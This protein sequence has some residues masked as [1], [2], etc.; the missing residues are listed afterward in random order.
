MANY[1]P[2][3]HIKAL[4]DQQLDWRNNTPFVKERRRGRSE[5][6]TR[7]GIEGKGKG[8]LIMGIKHDIQNHSQI[9]QAVNSMHLPPKVTSYSPNQVKATKQRQP[10]SD[11]KTSPTPSQASTNTVI[12]VRKTPHNILE[13]EA[14]L[15]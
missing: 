8:T 9:G 10:S 2:D 5:N 15:Y 4:Y 13:Q 11:R 1:P 12:R 14:G 6:R 7:W 3:R